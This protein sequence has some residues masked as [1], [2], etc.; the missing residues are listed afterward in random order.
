MSINDFKNIRGISGEV[1]QPEQVRQ[2]GKPK[3]PS[4]E[5]ILTGVRRGPD[6]KLSAHAQ[7]RIQARGLKIGDPELTRLGDAMDM[8][9]DKGCRET[10]MLM[11]DSALVVSVPNRTVITAMGRN[12]LQGNIVTNIDSTMIV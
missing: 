2:P 4:F 1:R 11:D 8:A 10:L 3:G 9:R 6:V 12:D 7:Q 5:D